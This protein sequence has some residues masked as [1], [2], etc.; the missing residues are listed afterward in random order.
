MPIMGPLQVVGFLD[1]G[2]STI[3]RKENI[4]I[5]GPTTQVDLEESTNNVW[6]ASTGAEVQFLMPGVNIPFRLIFAYNPLVLNS[7]IIVDATRFPLQ[8][9]KKRFFFFVLIF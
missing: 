5:F 9:E 2:T 4:R 6:R 1:L 7:S 3:L 8:E